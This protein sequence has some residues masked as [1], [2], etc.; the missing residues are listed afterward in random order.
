MILL[1]LEFHDG[2]DV[3]FLR[4]DV[5]EMENC[6]LLCG[7]VLKRDFDAIRDNRSER[8]PLICRLHLNHFEIESID[9][10]LELLITSRKFTD[11]C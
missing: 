7:F 6:G 10:V 5:L 8:L 4:L 2:F 11:L 1:V 3:A 9:C